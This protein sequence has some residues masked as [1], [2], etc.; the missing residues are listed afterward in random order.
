MKLYNHYCRPKKLNIEPK[1]FFIG[2]R[3]RNG[4]IRKTVRKASRF[5][6]MIK[7]SCFFNQS[8]LQWKINK[9]DREVRNDLRKSK[10]LYRPEKVERI[11]QKTSEWT[12]NK[13]AGYH[14]HILRLPIFVKKA[15][16]KMKMFFFSKQHFLHH[17]FELFQLSNFL[18]IKTSQLG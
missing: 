18:R 17:I 15:F 11:R 4:N 9:T 12:N 1:E 16:K 6:K 3:I 13:M 7:S 2:K 14:R 5:T 10:D 8:T